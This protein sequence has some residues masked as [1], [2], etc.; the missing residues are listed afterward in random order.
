MA[1]GSNAEIFT[2][3]GIIVFGFLGGLFLNAGIDPEGAILNAFA[4]II[5]DYAWHLDFLASYLH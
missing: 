4:T 1:K 5:P 3:E 2:K